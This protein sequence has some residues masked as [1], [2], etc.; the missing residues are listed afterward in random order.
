MC[1][2]SVGIGSRAALGLL[3]VF[4]QEIFVAEMGIL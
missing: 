2:G 3:P 1:S 4:D